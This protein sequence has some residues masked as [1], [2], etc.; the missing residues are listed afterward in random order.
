MRPGDVE[1]EELRDAV[2]GQQHGGAPGVQPR[3]M[4]F[5]AVAADHEGRQPGL[6]ALAVRLPPALLQQRQD[7]RKGSRTGLAH[8][9]KFK[10]E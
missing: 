5:R 9:P 2:A 3:A 6:K 7:P 8:A 10:G 1:G 4:A